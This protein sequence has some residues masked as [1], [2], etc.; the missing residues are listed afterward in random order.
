LGCG[1]RG[2]LH[3]EL[4]KPR[5]QVA[6]EGEKNLSHPPAR[7][8]QAAIDSLADIRQKLTGMAKQLA[9]NTTIPATEFGPYLQ[10]QAQ[11]LKIRNQQ[12]S[13]WAGREKFFERER[14]SDPDMSYWGDCT[15]ACPGP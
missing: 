2:L 10:E 8:A 4:I 7:Y 12:Y 13:Q 6:Q 15:L 9:P 11:W 5:A 1:R 3:F 14:E